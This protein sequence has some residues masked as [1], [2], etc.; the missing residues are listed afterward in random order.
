M[1]LF[2]TGASSFVGAHFCRLAAE[3]GHV[4]RGLWRSTAL[5]LPGVEG[6]RGDVLERAPPADTDVVVHLAAKVMAADSRA[7]NR[8][9]MDA[10]LSWGLPVAYGSSTV[11]HWPRT[12]A[13][14]DARLEDEARLMASGRPWLV[15][16]PCAPYGPRLRHHTPAHRESF[17]QLAGWVR[18]L[19]ALPLVGLGRYRR[20]PVHVDDFNGALLALLERG[21][22]GRAFDAGAPA[23]LT[24]RRLL[25]VLGE[26]AGH[27]PLVLPVPGRLAGLGARLVPGFDPEL[28]RTFATDDVVDAAPLAAA[29]GLSPRPFEQ[30][31]ACLYGD[32]V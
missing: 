29:S 12:S 8:R 25:R 13:Y 31:A 14:A 27:H 16:R 23:P 30:G 9:M 5:A 19:P 10:V 28:V 17:H 4:V 11:V 3:R 20:Q 6:V 21:R 15:L 7:Q 24:M 26:A 32:P 1:K 22:W 18:R 2:V